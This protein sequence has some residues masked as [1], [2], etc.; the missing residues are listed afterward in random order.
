MRNYSTQDELP[1]GS[2]TNTQTFL[3]TCVLDADQKALEGHLMNNQVQQS[4]LDSCLLRG[5][6]MVQQNEKELSHVAKAL[7]MLLQS[8]AKWNSDVLLDDQKTPLHIVCES[9]GDHHELLELIINSFQQTLINAQDIN[10]CTALLYAVENANINCIRCLLANGADATGEAD[11][12]QLFVPGDKTILNPIIK[13]IWM[14][15]CVSK[16]SSVIM[17]DIFDVLLD[18]A[19]QRNQDHLRNCTAYILC[20]LYT[21]NDYCTNKLIKTGAP[22]D[23]PIHLDRYAWAY[24][25]RRGNAELLKSM[26]NRGLDKES[27]DL[28]SES[29]LGHAICGGK[30][31]GIRCLLDLGVTIPSCI[32]EVR[33]TK[34]E[35]CKENRLIIEVYGKKDLLDPCMKAIRHD[36]LEIVK[37]L[38][39]YGGQR[40]KSF[41]ALRWGVIFGNVDVTTYLL[42]KYSY[43]LNIEYTK[44]SV[45][46]YIQ[47]SGIYTILTERRRCHKTQIT[48][49]LLDH[50][51]DPTKKMCS[52]TSANAMMTAIESGQLEDIAQYIRSGVDINF[53]SYH[54]FYKNMLP[55]EAS[56]L[57]RH[58]NIAEILL[59]S[60]CS[61]GVFSLKSNHQF[62]NNLDPEVVKLMKE[63]Q[64]EDNN[65]IPLQQRC[66][67]VILKHLSPQAD[68][69]IRKLPLP[70]WIIKF[71][72]ISEMDDIVDE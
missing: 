8:D 7:T 6:R 22:L 67:S 5:L 48:K 15:G 39:E 2:A 57:L 21:Y 64:V 54:D 30:I 18:A 55:F 10:R 52:P 47:E 36:K 25:V 66:R 13:A 26:F 20:A 70:K 44:V 17:S 68:E 72:N 49:L 28:Q 60:G 1:T 53:R 51:A 59:I 65:V 42:N 41:T 9:H 29:V 58:H 61:C 31:E 32:P 46:D 12:W 38:D 14:S 34:C 45:S 50:G 27:V 56:V 33:T 19:V 37:L 43:P 40:S 63:W 16:Y 4:D 3:E 11:K 69:K 35:Q 24:I 71:L 23:Q 62:K